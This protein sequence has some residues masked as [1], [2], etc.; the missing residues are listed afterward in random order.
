MAPRKSSRVADA[1]TA[2]TNKAAVDAKVEQT[3]TTK[4]ATKAA[5][6][7]KEKAAAKPKANTAAKRATTDNGKPMKAA[8][9]KT[10]SSLHL[11]V[12]SEIISLNTTLMHRSGPKRGHSKKDE[13]APPTEKATAKRK[14]AE[15]DAVP[16]VKK[17]TKAKAPAKPKAAAKPK[18]EPKPKAPPK[19]KLKVVINELR[20]TD[21]LNIFVCGEGSGGELGLGTK[22]NALDVKRPRL[23][24]LLSPEE[25]GV[26]RLATGGMHCVALTHD[27]KILTWGV[28]DNGALGRDTTTEDVAMRDIDDADSKSDSSEDEDDDSGLN[29]KEATPTAISCDVFPEG[30]TFVDIAA[31]DSMSFALTDDGLVYGW[32]TFRVSSMFLSA[33]LA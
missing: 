13:S 5:T 21:K 3:T 31:G 2:K 11:Y 26:V 17:A 18:R 1:E 30:T 8:T 27:N 28:N 20:F 24:K 9:G 7:K 33:N 15:H 29:P 6:T 10:L 14:A 4:K 25:V 23:N 19:P 32:G 12:R 22:N 16:P